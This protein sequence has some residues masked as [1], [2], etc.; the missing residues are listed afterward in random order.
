MS[1]SHVWAYLPVSWG[2]C[3]N[4][5][6]S[7]VYPNLHIGL[8]RNG[9]SIAPGSSNDIT[10]SGN[11]GPGSAKRSSGIYLWT[12]A[13]DLPPHFLHLHCPSGGSGIVTP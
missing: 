11:L 3:E 8:S 13:L 6:P 12:L 9:H 7:K 4:E 1:S 10:A 2:Y 5:M